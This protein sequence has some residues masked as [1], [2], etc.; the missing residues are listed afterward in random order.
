MKDGW[1]LDGGDAGWWAD[2]REETT[3]APAEQRLEVPSA[4]ALPNSPEKRV[5]MPVK[6]RP[7]CNAGAN[8]QASVA[9]QRLHGAWARA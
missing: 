9:R 5:L 7:P 3:Q 4:R 6:T 2:G 1:E 8:P